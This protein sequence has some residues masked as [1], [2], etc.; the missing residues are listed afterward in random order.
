[1]TTIGRTPN[2]LPASW[3]PDGGIGNGS[4]WWVK[5]AYTFGIPA[6]IALF[7]LW[8]VTSSIAGEIKGAR[9][10]LRNH[11]RDQ[12]R[13]SLYLRAICLNTAPTEAA[14]AQCPSDEK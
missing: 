1:M 6:G 10:D 14:R 4:P 3:P 12:A 13:Q 11:M 2:G 7:L 5:A 9:E 8:F